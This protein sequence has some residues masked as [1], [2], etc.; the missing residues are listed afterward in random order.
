M[1]TIVLCGSMKVKNKI[2]EVGN[3]LSQKG[4]TVLYPDECL[5]NLPKVEASRA[6]FKRIIEQADIVLVV[7]ET[8]NGQKNYIGP[9]TLAEIAFA[10]YF[11][12]EIYLYNNIYDIYQDELIAWNA[13]PLDG[14]LDLIIK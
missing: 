3:H 4:Y 13:L 1:K 7:N 11:N 5:N 6:H 8:K 9:N 2:L 12:K 10:F 14:N